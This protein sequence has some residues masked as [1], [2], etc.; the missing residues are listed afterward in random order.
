MFGIFSATENAPPQTCQD[1][2]NRPVGLKK[3]TIRKRSVQ[4]PQGEQ[5]RD[6]RENNINQRE[7]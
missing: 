2:Q 6:W 4:N 7:A 5:K 1:Q 3:C